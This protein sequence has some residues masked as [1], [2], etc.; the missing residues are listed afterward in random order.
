MRRKYHSC[1]SF[2][3]LH[4]PFSLSLSSFSLS[5]SILSLSHT[6]IRSFTHTLLTAIKSLGAA[7]AEAAKLQLIH[8]ANLLHTSRAMLIK[9][10]SPCGGAPLG[11]G[12]TWF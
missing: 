1:T 11:S 5:L 4:S 6:I 3:I 7:Q 12:K 10:Y 8:F 9:F 2:S